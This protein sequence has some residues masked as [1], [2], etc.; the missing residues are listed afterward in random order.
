MIIAVIIAVINVVKSFNFK[1][2][3]NELLSYKYLKSNFHYSTYFGKSTALIL[4]LIF[5]DFPIERL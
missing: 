1:E 4:I 5:F 3:R 2:T